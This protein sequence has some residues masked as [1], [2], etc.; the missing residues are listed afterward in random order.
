LGEQL[1]QI[2]G[3]SVIVENKP[4]ANGIVAI[5][6]LVSSKPTLHPD[7]RKRDHQCNHAR[8]DARQGAQLRKERGA[9]SNLVDIRYSWRRHEFQCQK[10]RRARSTMPEE[11]G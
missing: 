9:V 10:R 11:S 6:E 7:D 1:R 8:A 4:G 2:L 5:N 3:Q